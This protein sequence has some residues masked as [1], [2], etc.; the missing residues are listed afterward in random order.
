MADVEG[1]HSPDATPRGLPT[2][3]AT[4][5]MTD[6]EN[7]TVMWQEH[8][9]EV[10][11]VVTDRHYD[12]LDEVVAAHGGVRPVEQGEGDSIV[13]GFADAAAAVT[14]AIAI[15][16]TFQQ[17]PW[18]DGIE[19]RLRVAL[20]TDV[21]EV[22]GDGDY[23][24]NPMIRTARLRAAGHGLQILMSDTT[25][26]TVH[27]A[28]PDGAELFDR[29]L[30]R[31]KGLTL[32]EK[33]WELRHTDLAVCDRPPV[34][35][36]AQQNNLPLRSPALL[37]RESAV[38]EVGSH[39]AGH[40]LVTLVGTGGVGKTTLA[41][42]VGHEALG[43]HPG[44]VWFVELAPVSE[45]TAVA[46]AILAALSLSDDG[47]R[48]PL[49]LAADRLAASG[50]AL[51]ILDNCEHLVDAVAHVVTELRA[52]CPTLDVL[53]TSRAPLGLHDEVV[54]RVPVLEL[55]PATTTIT[56]AN[57]GQFAAMELFIDAARRA[58][59]D[60]DVGDVQAE[61]IA[62]ICRRLDG[63]PLA[64]EL[65]AARCR[66]MT[67]ERI[68]SAIAD[69]F[70]LLTSGSTTLDRRQQ[71]LLASV[72]WSYDLLGDDERRVIR[73]LAV[74]AGPFLPEAAE[75]VGAS[76]GDIDP[77]DVLDKLGDL[78]DKSLVQFD[79]DGSYRL[80]ETVR[81]FA[82]DRAEEAG[83]TTRLR[84][85]HATWWISHL[86]AMDARQPSRA[87]VE[88]CSSYRNDL[89]AALETLDD[90][91]DMRYRLLALVGSNWDFG[92]H[93]DDLMTF[94]DRWVA[95]GPPDDDL[96]LEWARCWPAAAA[97]WFRTWR[98]VDKRLAR[99]AVDCLLAARDAR[100]VM[101]SYAMYALFNEYEEDTRRLQAA[102]ALGSNAPRL[103]AVTAPWVVGK[104][105]DV[106][107]TARVKAA[108]MYAA[109]R[110]HHPFPEFA[111]PDVTNTWHS[112]QALA[113]PPRPGDEL[114]LL[115]RLLAVHLSG[116]GAMLRGD[117]DAVAAVVE[118]LRPYEGLT[119]TS[120]WAT[121]T[122]ALLS[123]L[124]DRPVTGAE[125]NAIAWF[126]LAGETFH[127]YFSARLLLA[128][129]GRS[130][131][132]ILW[133]LFERPGAG[134]V[135]LP[136]LD[137]V[138]ALHADDDE[139]A[140]AALRT[141]LEAHAAHTWPQGQYDIV[142][143]AA[144]LAL[145]RGDA[146]RAAELLHAARGSRARQ[147]VSFRYPDQRRWLAALDAPALEPLEGVA[148]DTDADTAIASL[149]AEYGID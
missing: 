94:A 60:L 67:P 22:R 111:A 47:L 92:G 38:R 34:T 56:A 37:G 89:R 20:H 137:I 4:L 82:R 2:G 99:R 112:D 118:V 106:D 85:A 93:S 28:L 128:T 49:S 63:I 146:D 140:A 55:P 45:P 27:D 11:R 81:D 9:P 86:E 39:L 72:Q 95:T 117:E 58:R 98:D 143:L 43:A 30:H 113:R 51:L 44:G 16:R 102:V 42:E 114:F 31:L 131:G 52:H 70:R 73:R 149:R 35:I 84:Q 36:G 101:G 88:I 74:F 103:Y 76:V 68:A 17:E 139:R 109:L 75:S 124:H 115:D 12:L 83:E 80:L 5:L 26:Q 129:G 33:I 142:E 64:I 54:W 136:V 110:T 50:A 116:M 134:T 53:I 13:A 100:G 19:M 132:D 141:T 40:A 77:W 57:A 144:V 119:M 90:E 69:R 3:L 105:H 6:V 135:A 8:T 130:Y 61:A 122:Q 25:A 21:L 1:P 41:V 87:S 126:T 97:V 23:I 59:P 107:V 104:L 108:P 78:V 145:R 79:G 7:S 91:F 127:R 120:M 133:K 147:S 121:G 148:A 65:A 18:P 62:D 125:H 71:T 96:E 123:V 10:M 24:G 46:T 29:G 48:P 15:Q 66:Q 32:P 138:T 14:A